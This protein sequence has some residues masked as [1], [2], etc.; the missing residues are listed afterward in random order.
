M[1]AAKQNYSIL[2]KF[3]FEYQPVGVKFLLNRPEGLPRTAKQLP[4]CRLFGEAQT[5]PPF[6]ADKDTFTCVDRLVLGMVAPEPTMES[7]QIGAKERIYQ[8]ARANRRIYHHIQ[9]FAP[10]TV[11]YV[12]FSSVDKLSFA[13]D[14]L[15]LTAAPSQAE[16]LLRALSYSTGKPL[17]S[18]ITP[19]LMCAWLFAYPYLSGELN[20]T[21]T[22]IGYG[23]RMQKIL[24]EGLFVISVPFD[25]I[26]ML[27]DNLREMEWVLPMTA[28]GEA[29]RG[30]FAARIMEEIQ[31]EYRNG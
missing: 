15:I 24:P 25:L 3:R 6:Y 30:E 11:R 29:E 31:Q 12:A 8:E 14:L 9:K 4:I 26:P 19:V 16:I 18:K 5:S 7:G 21:V 2:D 13:P 27:L 23:F 22:G 17:T 20:Y 10:D 28:L 1:S